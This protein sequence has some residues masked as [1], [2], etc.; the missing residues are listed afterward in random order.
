MGNTLGV[1]EWKEA[2]LFDVLCPYESSLLS[3]FLDSSTIFVPSHGESDFL[4]TFDYFSSGHSP[5]G[6]CS[7][8]YNLSSL[9]EGFQQHLSVLVSALEGLQG[10]PQGVLCRRGGRGGNESV[11]SLT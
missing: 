2:E 9:E 3:G 1:I 6:Y 7:L 5:G 10:L 11:E 8:L 4:L